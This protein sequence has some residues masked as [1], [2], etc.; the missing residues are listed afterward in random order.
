MNESQWKAKFSETKEEILNVISRGK[1]KS[2]ALPKWLD[3]FYQEVSQESNVLSTQ[4]IRNID[5]NEEDSY[6]KYLEFVNMVSSFVDNIK[7]LLIRSLPGDSENLRKKAFWTIVILFSSFLLQRYG[8]TMKLLEAFISIFDSLRLPFL[9]N[10]LIFTR[11]SASNF[12]KLLWAIVFLFDN[13]TLLSDTNR[14]NIPP[15][16]LY[17]QQSNFYL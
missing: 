17:N 5:R 3:R 9:R 16:K 15:R 13:F 7:D 10:F 8:Y 6:H 4:G 11:E 2:P 14:S 1:K 12:Y